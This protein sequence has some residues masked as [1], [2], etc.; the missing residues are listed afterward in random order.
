MASLR[1]LL[2]SAL[3]CCWLQTT[4]ADTYPVFILAGQSNMEGKADN[5]LLEHQASDPPT[6]ELFAHWRQDGKWIERDDVSIKFLNRQGPLTIGYG[7]PNKTG[8]ELEFGYAVGEHYQQPVLLIK[9]AW[10][11]HSLYQKFR[12][13][14]AGLPSDE[15]LE[16][17]L[18][19][20]QQRVRN[21]NEKRNRNDPLPT[22][23]EI[24]AEY[25]VSYRNMMQEVDSTLKNA[26]TLFPALKGK[27]PEIAG[28]VWFQGFNDMFGDDAPGEYAQNMKLLIQDVRKAWNKPNLPVVI[29]ALGQNGSAEPSERMKQVQDAQLSM[30]DVPE[31][32]GNVKTIRT[33]VLVDKKAEELIDGWQDHVEEWKKVGSDRAYHYYGSPIWY[34]RIGKALAAEMLKMQ[35][36]Q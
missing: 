3:A 24:K 10:G 20:A 30:N 7:S 32:A 1:I 22:M 21:N 12:P 28:F 6:A 14:S 33:D 5:A 26:D 11:G 31:F 15:A 13:P 35:Q 4:A 19:Q 17:E 34:G 25:G 27:T 8:L 29:G 2:A 23:E 16:K 9:T 18:A 36:E